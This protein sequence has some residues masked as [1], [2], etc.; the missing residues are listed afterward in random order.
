[1]SHHHKADHAHDTAPLAP[2]APPTV[3]VAEEAT[4]A[5]IPTDTIAQKPSGE[6]MYKSYDT[7]GGL[8]L[9][10]VYM[11]SAVSDEPKTV[12]SEADLLLINSLDDAADA[13]DRPID[14]L[15]TDFERMALEDP[16]EELEDLSAAQ[17]TELV[18]AINND[19]LNNVIEANIAGT[20]NLAFDELVS[21][22]QSLGDDFKHL[23]DPMPM[24]DATGMAIP[25]GEELVQDPSTMTYEDQK[26][27]NDFFRG[28]IKEDQLTDK[29]KEFLVQSLMRA[30]GGQGVNS[31]EVMKQFFQR[32]QQ[33]HKSNPVL[34]GRPVRLKQRVSKTRDKKHKGKK[35]R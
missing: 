8:P 27:L 14:P 29:Q 13:D 28:R 12:L 19:H 35:K 33:M 21:P 23:V 15:V 1:M 11:E 6:V 26:A 22:A 10:E 31:Q 3:Q 4:F 25:M 18:H 9:D 2:L 32:I 30:G 20:P 7:E 24:L 34:F 5:D 16:D 17:T